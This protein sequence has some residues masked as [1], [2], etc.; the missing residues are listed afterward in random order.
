MWR[1]WNPLCITRGNVKW[2]SF[3]RKEFGSSSKSETQNYHMIQQSLSR[4]YNQKEL[5]AETKMLVQ[6]S[7]QQQHSQQP[8]GRLNPLVCRMTLSFFYNC[9]FVSNGN[10]NGD[11][12]F[13]DDNGADNGDANRIDSGEDD[14]GDGDLMVVVMTLHR[15][16]VNIK[17]Q[18]RIKWPMFVRL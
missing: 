5:K 17:I 11:E 1:N 6:H 18:L 13:S 7:S 14:V 2:C 10:E 3:C 4:L 8:K 12:D 16:V 15:M 9:L